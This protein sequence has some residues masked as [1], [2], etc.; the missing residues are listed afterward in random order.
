[1]ASRY[2]VQG[3][4]VVHETVE[5]EAIIIHL[6]QG[7]YFSLTEAGAC[8]WDVVVRGGDL[9]AAV[10]AVTRAFDVTPEVATPAVE[11][12]LATLVDET[13]AVVEDG[14]PVLGIATAPEDGPRRP[15]SEP[16]LARFTD[17]QELL[18]ADPI[19][20]VADAGWPHVKPI[21]R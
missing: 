10:D 9:T 20:E 12:L 11:R 4:N 16:A 14:P 5:R 21:A 17:M 1:M 8:V 3:P 2:R 18:L 19:H 15:W 13:L 6:E 7:T